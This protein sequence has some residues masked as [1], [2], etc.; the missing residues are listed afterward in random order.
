MVLVK[1][2]TPMRNMLLIQKIVQFPIIAKIVDLVVQTGQINPFKVV[3]PIRR[4]NLTVSMHIK[5]ERS[6]PHMINEDTGGM[7]I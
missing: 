2:L 1:I 3:V 7:M 5:H 6:T 4:F